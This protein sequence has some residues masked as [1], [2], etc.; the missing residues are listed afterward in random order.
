MPKIAVTIVDQIRESAVTA[1]GGHMV[2]KLQ[3]KDGGDLPLAISC[4]ELAALIDHS[5]LAMERCEAISRSGL[6]PEISATWWNSVVDPATKDFSLSVTFGSGG[7]LA[8]RFSE[9]MAK[10]LLATLSGHYAVQVEDR[11]AEASRLGSFSPEDHIAPGFID[12]D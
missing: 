9:R 12:V 7:R 4:D 11:F 6:D 2:L 8:F 3:V 5:A 10:A 1:D